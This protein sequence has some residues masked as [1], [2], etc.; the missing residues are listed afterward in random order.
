MEGLEVPF[1]E[2]AC[3]GTP[4]VS[5]VV[6][7]R[8]VLGFRAGAEALRK[9]GES[10]GDVN[11]IA[12]LVGPTYIREGVTGWNVEDENGPVPLDIEAIL[13]NY[14]WAYPIADRADDIYSEA[15]LAPLLK[16]MGALSGN[17]RI[18]ASTRATR[19]S[20]GSRR[21]RPVSSSQNGS[22]GRPSVTSP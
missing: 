14:T 1:R 18:V 4:H 5:D 21:S 10:G 19:R 11:L 2:C 3:P 16:R 13:G 7:L 17:G 8:P 20:S 12:E 15:V 6:Y 9:M 22:A